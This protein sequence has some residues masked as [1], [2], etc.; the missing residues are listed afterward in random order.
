MTPR[1]ADGSSKIDRCGEHDDH[2]GDDELSAYGKRAALVDRREPVWEFAATG[3]REHG[4][5]HARHEVEE[6]AEC[7]DA[8]ADANDR[9]EPVESGGADD[10]AEWCVARRDR[11]DG[12]GGE[13][14]DADDRVE[15]QHAGEGARDRLRDRRRRVA[16][17]LA[18]GGDSRIAGEGEEQEPGGAQDAAWSTCRSAS[19]RERGR[20][21]RPTGDD[22]GG[23]RHERDGEQTLGDDHGAGQTADVDDRDGADRGDA[24]ESR[25]CSGHRYAPAVS[26]RATQRRSCRRRTPIP[27]R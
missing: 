22:D 27:A 26:A 4:A 16:H 5:G 6:D 13:Q 2:S 23:E 11:I 18:E 19:R 20:R 15:H 8:G 24:D 21:T 12:H 14:R 7:G 10:E 1:E 17:L 9:G 3:H 25:A